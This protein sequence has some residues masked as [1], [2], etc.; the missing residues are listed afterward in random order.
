[1]A[2][3][4]ERGPFEFRKL[5]QK[6]HAIVGE[7]DL[8]RT[9]KRAA[10]EK[11]D[12]ADGVMGRTKWSRRNKRSL[13][14]QKSG[15]AVNLGG[16]DRFVERHRR[17]NRRHPFRQHRFAGTG[18]SNH[19]NV[20]ATRNRDFD[21][22]LHVSLAFHVGKIDVARQRE[23]ARAIAD[24]VAQEFRARGY[25]VVS[26]GSRAADA[27]LIVTVGGDGTLLRAARVAVQDD[28]PVLGIN[29]GRL[30]F[31]TEFDDDDPRIDELPELFERGLH[32]EERVA[33]QAQ[34]ES[35]TFFALNDVVVRKGGVSRIVPFGLCLGREQ[36][37]HVP[38]DGICVA[39]PTGSTAYFL[40]AGGS[41]ISPQVDAFG[42]VPLLPHTLFSRPLI[43]PIDERIV[44]SCD[45]EM[46][47][48]NLEC[49][50]DVVSD[51]SPG[52]SVVIVRHP[53]TVKFARTSALRFFER[54][55]QK[56][57]WGVSIKEERAR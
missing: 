23:N 35:R 57:R 42:I 33:L 31:L 26:D 16:F 37:A 3:H 14:V 46:V 34:Y 6:Q 25:T 5:I 38:A 24:R 44:V 54:L 13:A 17:N 30:G 41:I 47:H 9:W 8:A 53:R 52:S 56:L 7:T 15:D 4:F 18:R 11:S 39:T 40:S 36:A 45:D 22:A 43:V 27:K 10:A 12:I 51:V 50:G 2:H 20:V 48:A 21:C 32:I 19:E 29:T 1:L 49:D 55:E 28:I